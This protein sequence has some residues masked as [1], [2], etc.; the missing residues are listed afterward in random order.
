M[1][2]AKGIPM[3]RRKVSIAC[4]RGL[5]RSRLLQIG[6]ILAFWLAGERLARWTGLPIPGGILAMAA[7]LLLLVSGILSLSSMRRGANWFLAEMLLFF[8]PAV[9]AVLDHHEFLGWLGLKILAVILLGTVTVM[10]VTAFA[11]DL[12]CLWS[13]RYESAR[14]GVE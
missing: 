7:V 8:I 13:A 1:I 6:M 14:R 5:H 9:P 2:L 12:L 10:V 11:V 4:R 3:I